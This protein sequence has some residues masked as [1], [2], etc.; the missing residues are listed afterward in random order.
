MNKFTSDVHNDEENVF[1]FETL[2]KKTN[3]AIKKRVS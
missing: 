3:N 1:S 2:G